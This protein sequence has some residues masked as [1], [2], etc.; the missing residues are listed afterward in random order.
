MSTFMGPFQIKKF[1]G[2]VRQRDAFRTQ[3]RLVYLG[4]EKDLLGFAASPAKNT[5]KLLAQ[6]NLRESF[7]RGRAPGSTIQDQ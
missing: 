3:I 5:S 6:P 1:G 4:E 2:G 7:N